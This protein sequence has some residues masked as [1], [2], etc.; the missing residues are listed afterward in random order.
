MRIGQIGKNKAE[1]NFSTVSNRETSS[2]ALGTPVVFVLD[3]T[4]DGFA[5]QLPSSSNA[6]KASSCPAGIAGGQG[7]GSLAASAVGQVVQVYGIC[8]N[9]ILETILTRS[10]T[11]AVW[12]SV[13][14]F[15]V[16]DIL[17]IDTVANALGF[18]SAGSAIKAIHPFVMAQTLVS[19]TTAASG[20]AGTYALI[21]TATSGNG[22]SSDTIA[23]ITSLAKVF[24]RVM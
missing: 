10:A 14:A 8:Q 20:A 3:G 5:V 16:G 12:A 11:S 18:L 22:A 1:T 17:T 24:V 13:A 15:S 9:A 4:D 23:Y 2:I 21:G 19:R 7:T 6:A